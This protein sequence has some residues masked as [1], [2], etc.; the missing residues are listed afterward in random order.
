MSN[1][2]S[3]Q[4][5]MSNEMPMNSSDNRTYLLIAY[6]VFLAGVTILPFLGTLVAVFMA[7]FRRPEVQNTIYVSHC[8]WII[9]TFWYPMW[10]LAILLGLFFCALL[11]WSELLFWV[12][13]F[14]AIFWVIV[15]VTGL[16]YLIR[17]I[18]G[19]IMLLNNK[20]I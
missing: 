7:Y 2:P 16:W 3:N 1:M 8:T 14:M 17:L 12:G 6:G 13:G 5:N 10:G 15:I 4:N 20:A 19:L 18:Y 9:R 11:V